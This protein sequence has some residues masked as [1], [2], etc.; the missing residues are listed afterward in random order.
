MR[1]AEQITEFLNIDSQE[2]QIF[3][4]EK[5]DK[6]TLDQSDDCELVDLIRNLLLDQKLEQ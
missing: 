1:E 3:D 2:H 6:N 5:F 4:Y